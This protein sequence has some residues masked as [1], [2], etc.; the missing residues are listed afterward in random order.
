MTKVALIVGHEVH[1]KAQGAVNYKGETESSFNFRITNKIKKLLSKYSIESEVFIRDNI[2]I[3]GVAQKVAQ[4]NPNLSIEFHFNSFHKIAVGT[5][6]LA[7]KDDNESIIFADE[8]TDRIQE[9]FN[10]TQRNQNGVL[11][12]TI[13]QNGYHN[14]KYLEQFQKQYF[15][16]ILIEPV[17]ANIKTPESMAI[18]ENEDK[19][20]STIT[21]AIVDYFKPHIK[22][23][24]NNI[25][26]IDL[27]DI[28]PLQ[29]NLNILKNFQ[30]Y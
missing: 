16:K 9:S 20:V 10:I 11:L 14:L 6:A 1:G 28:N 29:L 8:I 23:P 21:S 24:I 30:G 7:L 2:G 3:K 22:K 5:E 15:P 13:N 19:Y 25:L 26:T 17:F 27:N 18:F 12:T 4:Y